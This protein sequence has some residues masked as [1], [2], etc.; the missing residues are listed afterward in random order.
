M[1][2]S[3]LKILLSVSVLTTGLNASWFF[4]DSNTEVGVKEYNNLIKIPTNYIVYKDTEVGVL[5]YKSGIGVYKKIEV[6]SEVEDG[7]LT[8]S[9][10]KGVVLT[11]INGTTILRPS[12]SK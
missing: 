10:K 12:G 3:F 4:T 1:K 6:I 9:L 7:I 5:I 2:K 8:D 11:S